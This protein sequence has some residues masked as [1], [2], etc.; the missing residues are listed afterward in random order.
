[1]G[2]T[3]NRSTVSTT[4]TTVPLTSTFAG[5]QPNVVA[6]QSQAQQANSATFSDTDNAPYHELYNGRN[7]FQS[8]TFNIDTQ[9]AIQDYLHDQASGGSIYSP[10]QQLNYN[11][12]MGYP[13]TAN[14]QYMVDSLMDGMHNI[15]YN[16]TLTHFGRVGLIDNLARNIG[17]NIN[18]RNFE[19]MTDAQLQ[20]AFVGSTHSL[21]K[22]L[23]VSYNQFRNAPNGGRPFTDKAVKLN[24][25][26]PART[27][28]LMPG[29]GPGGNLGELVLA[30]QQNFRITGVRFTGD[31]GRSGGQTYRRVEFDIEFY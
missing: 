29:N 5:A 11:M 25:S 21:N 3:G 7:Y 17:A 12:E 2:A 6:T 13:L 9:L 27:Q 20:Q 28:A 31:R 19:S 24:I 23:S 30:P 16:T 14:Q 26:A 8:Q 4:G 18:S 1:M 15:G 10:S 22:F